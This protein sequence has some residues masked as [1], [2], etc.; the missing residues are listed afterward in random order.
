M[1]WFFCINKSII[2]AKEVLKMEEYKLHRNIICID[3]KSFYASVE[4]AISGLDPFKTPLVVADKERGGGS[5]VLAVSPYLKQFGV[6]NRCRVYELP[7]NI[8]IIYRKPKMERY[9][10]Y[11][12]K[13]VEIYLRFVS[14]EDIYVYS[15]DE[16][17][18]DLTE[19]LTYYNTNDYDFA[20]KILDTIYKE[21]KIYG[22]CGIGPNM[23]IA[24]L[25][26]DIES[27]HSPD[28]IAKWSYEDLPTKLWPVTPLSKMW[29]IGRNMEH[30]LNHM[31]IYKVED[32]AKYDVKKL[33]KKF[34]VIGE[35]LYY[36]SHGIDMSM[37]QEKMNIKPVSKSYGIGQTLFHDYY[38]PEIFQIIREMVDDVC[39]RLR[40]GKKLAKTVHFGLAYSKNVGGGFARQMTLDAPSQNESHIYRACLKIMDKFYDDSPIRVV[41][42]SVTNLIEKK[43]YQINLFEDI[44]EVLK[45]QAV[46]SAMDEIKERF[47][48]NS[49][50]RA[51]SELK[52]S[53]IKARNDMIGGHHA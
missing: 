28:F 32:L 11:S 30:N 1:Q 25:A 22:T 42:V 24:K 10:E 49:V 39:R 36:H 52:S 51:S 34:G 33:K 44:N 13:I 48:K 18:I 53:T 12:T 26:L 8:G 50:N 41:R 35:E 45:E 21:T 17:F 23:L 31:G 40:I 27:K 19:Y 43:A 6:P 20:R 14:E 47:G 4:C 2:F 38:R 5:I 16:V 46:F 7:K 9:L 3:L 29:G 15:V 37:I